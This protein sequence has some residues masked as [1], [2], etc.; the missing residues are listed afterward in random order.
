MGMGGK[1]LSFSK[2][3]CRNSSLDESYVRWGQSLLALPTT[4]A[5]YIVF[6]SIFIRGFLKDD[7]L[8]CVET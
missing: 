2:K 3:D 6:R 5:N 4:K 1:I 8:A 7:I